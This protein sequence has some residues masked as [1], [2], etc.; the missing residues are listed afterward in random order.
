MMNK[1]KPQLALPLLMAVLCLTA[2]GGSGGDDTESVPPVV[3]PPIVIE[4]PV[5]P[6]ESL[7]FAT[8]SHL[9]IK[10]EFSN[11]FVD[12]RGNIGSLDDEPVRI[13]AVESLSNAPECTLLSINDSG[14]NLAAQKDAICDYR[15]RVELV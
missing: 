7:V 1:L 4:P 12:L 6:V 3:E 11:Y 15:Y 2:C 13:A 10:P 8:D 5:I 14:F 9:Q